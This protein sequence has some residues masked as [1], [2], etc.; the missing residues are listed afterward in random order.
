LLHQKNKNK[1]S[2]NLYSK[3]TLKLAELCWSGKEARCTSAV[4]GETYHDAQG[5]KYKITENTYDELIDYQAKA[6][7]K[8]KVRRYGK[9]INLIGVN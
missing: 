7:Q 2:V 3:E 4:V 6:P 9:I 8:F 5:T 1:E